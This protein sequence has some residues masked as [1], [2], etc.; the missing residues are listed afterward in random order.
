MKGK[1]P[2]KQ[3]YIPER[4]KKQLAKIPQHSLTL[5]EAPSGFG[6]TTAVSDYIKENLTNEAHE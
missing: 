1:I 3:H 2:K 4:L 6:K 5:V